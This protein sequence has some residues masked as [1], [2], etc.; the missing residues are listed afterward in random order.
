MT[1]TFKKLDSISQA[2]VTTAELATQLQLWGDTSFDTELADLIL[3][4][5][6]HVSNHIG[7]PI[8]PT[9]I[10]MK[11]QSFPDFE[12]AHAD[13]SDYYITYY[14]EDDEA[15]TLEIT[16]YR[17]DPTGDLTSI[18]VLNVPELS[19]NFQYPITI[20]YTSGPDF[21]P[22]VVRHAILMVAAEL[23]E[24]RTESTDVKERRAAITVSRLLSADKR[25]V[26]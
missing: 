26:V 6:A 14:D 2:P 1:K 21:V 23:F 19:T 22:L 16:D 10:E 11:F 20:R 25:V 15:Q 24:V 8:S 13:T 7:K 5:T 17:V 18:T 9:D 3:T 4:A 12:L